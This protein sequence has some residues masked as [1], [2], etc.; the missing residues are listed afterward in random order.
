MSKHWA[1]IALALWLLVAVAMNTALVSQELSGPTIQAD[2]L[3]QAF[4]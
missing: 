2:D 1:T 4:R 3:A